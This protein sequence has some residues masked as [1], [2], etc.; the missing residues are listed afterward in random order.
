MSIGSFALYPMTF[1]ELQPVYL[2]KDSGQASEEW[3]TCTAEDFCG[4]QTEIEYRIDEDNAMSLDNWVE[5]Y[6]MTCSPKYQFGLFGSCFFV[7]VVISSLIFTPLAD[8]IG[9]RKVCLCGIIMACLA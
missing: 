4:K 3:Y 6:G 8:K 2:C 7:A 9:R 5:E 1:Y